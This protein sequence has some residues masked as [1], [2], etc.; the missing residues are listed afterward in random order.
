M[1]EY[2]HITAIFA[3]IFKSSRA[4]LKARKVEERQKNEIQRTNASRE[5]Y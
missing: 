5:G 3:S 4:K 1:G 2:S